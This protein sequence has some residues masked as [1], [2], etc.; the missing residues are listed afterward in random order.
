MST[1][2]TR[3]SNGCQL[4]H[5][6]GVDDHLWQRLVDRVVADEGIDQALAE[7]VMNEALGFLRLCAEDP[8][9]R[10]VP[11]T[12]VDPGW[13]A[14]ILHTREYAEFCQRTAGRFLHHAP[15]DADA[16]AADTRRTVDAMRRHGLAVDAALWER[17]GDCGGECGT[18]APSPRPRSAAATAL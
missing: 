18:P 11:S 14:F 6:H 1:V 8:A 17:G 4:A 2:V 12:A 9:G 10:Y 5:R 3:Q 16:D 13:H 7:R 15:F